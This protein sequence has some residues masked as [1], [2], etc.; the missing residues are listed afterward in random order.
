VPEIEPL[1]NVL[2]I[3]DD[4]AVQRVLRRLFRSAGYGVHTAGNGIA[5][6]EIF[7][8][9]APSAIVLDLGIPGMSGQDVCRELTRIA[10]ATPIVILSANSHTATKV[11]LLEMGASDYVTKPFRPRELVARLHAATRRRR[12]LS[13]EDIVVFDD[14]TVNFSKMETMHNGQ[15]VSLSARNF[16]LLTFLLRNSGYVIS[17]QKL[18]DEVCKNKHDRSV[19]NQIMLLRK[20][21]ERDP[22]TPVHFRTVH[23]VGYKFVP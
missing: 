22:L 17:R 18:Q 7:P 10:P 19:D 5:G 8:K 16:K 15:V 14:V 11:Q 9:V 6:L 12:Q 2:I 20:K 23:G 1:D 4:R 3:E 13:M 21:L